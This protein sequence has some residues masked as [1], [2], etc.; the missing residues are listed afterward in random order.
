MRERKPQTKGILVEVGSNVRMAMQLM[1]D[2]RQ[3]AWFITEFGELNLSLG[4]DGCKYIMLRLGESQWNALRYTGSRYSLDGLPAV[5]INAVTCSTYSDMGQ[6]FFCT[7]PT[8][9][10]S[11]SDTYPIL[12]K[13]VRAMC[14]AAGSMAHGDDGSASYEAAVDDWSNLLAFCH[15]VSAVELD[16]DAE[17]AALLNTEIGENIDID[18]FVLGM[19]SFVATQNKDNC[20]E[21]S[22]DLFSSFA[23]PDKVTKP[24]SLFHM[25]M[26]QGT[27]P[28]PID[29]SSVLPGQETSVVTQTNANN[30]VHDESTT[31]ASIDDVTSDQDINSPMDL[32]GSDKIENVDT[33]HGSNAENHNVKSDADTT[34][35]RDHVVYYEQLCKV[36]SDLETKY[37]QD[38]NELDTFKFRLRSTRYNVRLDF[39]NSFVTD[40]SAV[41]ADKLDLSRVNELHPNW[42]TI[43][44]KGSHIYLVPLTALWPL[45]FEIQVLSL[46]EENPV[47]RQRFVRLVNDHAFSFSFLETWLDFGRPSAMDLVKGQLSVLLLGP[48]MFFRKTAYWTAMG[49]ELILKSMHHQWIRDFAGVQNIT[50]SS[51]LATFC[52]S[53]AIDALHNDK[54]WSSKQDAMMQKILA[55]CGDNGTIVNHMRSPSKPSFVQDEPQLLDPNLSF[56]ARPG[57]TNNQTVTCPITGCTEKKIMNKKTRQFE[58]KNYGAF[59]PDY[60]VTV[61]LILLRPFYHKM[62][63]FKNKNYKSLQQWFITTLKNNLNT[64]QL[65][66]LF[67]FCLQSLWKAGIIVSTN[68]TKD[69]WCL[70]MPHQMTSD[71]VAWLNGIFIKLETKVTWLICDSDGIPPTI[72]NK[73]M[74]RSF[75]NKWSVP[76][77][78][79]MNW[80]MRSLEN[81]YPLLCH[82][83]DGKYVSRLTTASFK[84][85]MDGDISGYELYDACGVDKTE[86]EQTILKCRLPETLH[87]VDI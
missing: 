74:K 8:G 39:S 76:E 21:E 53:I 32:D 79:A 85:F 46:F 4:R 34:N 28:F 22:N 56:D 6:T 82:T 42:Q 61:S 41:N 9:E 62:Q 29:I 52:N 27:D 84:S 2:M 15:I 50:N 65:S 75:L 72:N 83:I 19:Q 73:P 55:Q 33:T 12:C 59:I 43:D 51:D 31:A 24:F 13:P 11:R 44:Y 67:K 7:F 57:S 45:E 5:W 54:D 87:F 36:I 70:S 64:Q 60:L 14:R 58:V 69:K 30:N 38:T 18:S 86:A 77:G 26:T 37:R 66:K 80:Y 23:A 25:D 16:V 10:Y 40:D 1:I 68:P 71:N 20:N 78:K 47:M 35:A 63:P 81:T 49:Y 3:G 17:D 48:C